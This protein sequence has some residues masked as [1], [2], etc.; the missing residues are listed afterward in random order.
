[1]EFAVSYSKISINIIS[2]ITSF[3]F[4]QNKRYKILNYPLTKQ[5]ESNGKSCEEIIRKYGITNY[6]IGK[7]KVNI[8]IN[9]SN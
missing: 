9:V 5:I 8:K 2:L 1:M 6:E 4:F 3:F 7:T